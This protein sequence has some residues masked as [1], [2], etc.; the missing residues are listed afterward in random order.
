MCLNFWSLFHKE[1]KIHV[2]DFIKERPST[3]S[4]YEYSGVMLDKIYDITDYLSGH[5]IFNRLSLNRIK[6]EHRAVFE[7][8]YVHSQYPNRTMAISEN[9]PACYLLFRQHSE[10]LYFARKGNFEFFKIIQAIYMQSLTTDV[11]IL[12]NSFEPV[13]RVEQVIFN[14][15]SV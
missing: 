11:L 10:G 1:K 4:T 2:D 13:K 5:G 12:F 7:K 6:R 9:L 14:S 3:N 8:F 15:K